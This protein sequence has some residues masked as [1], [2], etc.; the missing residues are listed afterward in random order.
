MVKAPCK[1]CDKMPCG[2]FHDECEAYQ[3][4]V[5]ERELEKETAHLQNDACRA[6]VWKR[7]LQCRNAA[8]KHKN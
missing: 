7:R 4:Y 3:M 5:L 2:S 1:D 8:V 6:H